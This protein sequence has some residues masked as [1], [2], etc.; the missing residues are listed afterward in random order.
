MDLV[1]PELHEETYTSPLFGGGGGP[2][3][4]NC[5]DD[6]GPVRGG[7]IEAP[8]TRIT[9]HTAFTVAGHVS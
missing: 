6:D 9:I 5:P 7:F 2:L 4:W 3:W 8:P 1:G